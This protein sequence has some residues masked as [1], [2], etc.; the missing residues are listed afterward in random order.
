MVEPSEFGTH[1]SELHRGGPG[2]VSIFDRQGVR[3]YGSDKR[4]S[5][6]EDCRGHDPLLKAVLDG[7]A[8]QSGV[9]RLPDDNENYIAARVPI[10]GIGWVAGARRPVRE[11]MAD[12]YAGLWIAGGLN[13]LVAVGSG[14]LAVKTS[15]GLIRQLRRLQTHADA[16][17]RGELEHTTESTGVRELAEL[18]TAFNRMGTAV[19]DAQQE[20]EAANAALEQRVRERTAQLAATIRRLES[21]VAERLRIAQELRAAS[22]YARGLIEASLDPLVTISPEGKVTDVNEATV[23]A[24]GVPRERLVGSD[25]SDYFTEPE[26]AGR[27]IG[28]CSPKGWSTTTR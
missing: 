23:A 12:V 11:V 28:R 14:L 18:A 22:L 17:A 2:A 13:L 19:H 5:G 1:V 8:E 3:V 26:R 27:A 25:F 4:R 16:I 21:E 10:E 9:L 20:L 7:H 24:T 15:G 6:H